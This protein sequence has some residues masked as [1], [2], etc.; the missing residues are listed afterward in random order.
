VRGRQEYLIAVTGSSANWR[1]GE[2][3][4]DAID[5]MSRYL[6]CGGIDTC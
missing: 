3:L 5:E 6:T 1:L 2:T 4:D